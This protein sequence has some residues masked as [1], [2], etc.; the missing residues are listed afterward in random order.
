MDSADNQKVSSDPQPEDVAPPAPAGANAWREFIPS[1]M[2]D[3]GYWEPVKNADLST[4]LKN[5]GNAQERLGRSITVPANLEDHHEVAKVMDKLGRPK[6]AKD[7]DFKLPDVPG[8]EWDTAALDNFKSLAHEYGLSK[9]QAKG[10][11]DWFGTDVQT[12][13]EAQTE[14]GLTQIA[15]VEAKLKRELGEN[16]DMKLA[17]AKRAGNLYFGTEATEAWFDTMPEQVVKGLIKLGSQLAEDKVFG[18]NLPEMN[19]VVSKDD[20]RRKIAEIGGNREHAFWSKHSNDA[21]HLA[22]VKEWESLHQIAYPSD[23]RL[24]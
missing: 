5:Y 6:E 16:H 21:A 3:K 2:K 22:A 18:H 8:Q 7:Y 11:I 19:G 9:A 20:A 1:D 13:T 4:V 17:L 15:T 23:A 24:G 12:R 10:V 14:A